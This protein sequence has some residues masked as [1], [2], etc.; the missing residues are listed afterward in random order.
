MSTYST[1]DSVP[2]SLH[3]F[4]HSGSFIELLICPKRLIKDVVVK[5]D[6]SIELELAFLV[7]LL[8]LYRG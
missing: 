6:I 7:V 2:G 8:F 1:S 5:K 4:I 3:I